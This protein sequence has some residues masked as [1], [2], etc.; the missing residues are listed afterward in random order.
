[1]APTAA[2]TTNDQLLEELLAFA[3][4]ERND[5][6]IRLVELHALRAEGEITDEEFAI[7]RL[8]LYA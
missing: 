2:P 1:M 7:R 5:L 8:G 4:Q 6:A 3:R